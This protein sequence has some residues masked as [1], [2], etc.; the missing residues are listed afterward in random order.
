MMDQHSPG[1]KDRS[2]ENCNSE[3]ETVLTLLK[4]T[5]DTVREIE[6]L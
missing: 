2:N 5:A 6:Q 4:Q 3:Y 1:R